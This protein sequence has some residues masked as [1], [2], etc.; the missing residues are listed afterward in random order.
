MG[1]KI[2]VTGANG[3]VATH[4]VSQLLKRGYKVRGTVRSI[5]KSKWLVEELFKS[6]A[7]SG[8]FELVEVLDM[9]VDGCFNDA[10]KDV[11]GIAHV[12]TVATF[13]PDPN[14]VIPQTVAGVA[15]ILNAA[16]K[17]PSVKALVY[18]SSVVATMPLPQAQ[19]HIDGTAWNDAAVK[20]AWA[21]PPYTSEG[22]ILT[23]V[24]RKVEA[25]K[26]LWGYVDEK[27][28]QFRVNSVL[29]YLIFGPLLHERQNTSTTGWVLA[30][31]REDT[32]QMAI[33]GG[34]L[35]LLDSRC[36]E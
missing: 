23:Y 36:C 16:A 14:K 21:P 28:P 13:N 1:S 26:A 30:L 8:D 5:T 34:M 17:E 12:A 25:E 24:V 31:T 15:N 10:F 18:T 4:P 9:A 20:M 29:L 3:L 2:L 19:M 32:T 6:Q 22:G 11:V 27:E 7:S 35:Q 33:P